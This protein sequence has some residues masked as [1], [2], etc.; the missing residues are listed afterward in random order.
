MKQ[1]NKNQALANFEELMKASRQS[2]QILYENDQPVVVMID[3]K[4]FNQL[5][6][7]KPPTI[8]EMLYQLTQ[9]QEKN[10]VELENIERIDRFNSII[11]DKS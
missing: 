11:D 9:I 1:W 6:P 4:L 2:P 8:S 7:P 3:I 5:S 10:P